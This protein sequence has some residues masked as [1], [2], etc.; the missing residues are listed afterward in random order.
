MRV[1]VVGLGKLGL[2]L[3]LLLGGEHDVTGIDLNE[4]TVSKLV[5]GIQPFIEP[6]LR[7]RMKISEVEY[8]S[9]FAGAGEADAT[10]IIVPTPSG[11]DGAFSPD[12]VVHAVELL[13]AELKG[14]SRPH[15]VVIVSTL[16]P[17]Q[18]ETVVQVALERASSRE[19]GTSLMLAY[20]PEFIALGDVFNGMEKPDLVLIGMADQRSGELTKTLLRSFIKNKPVFHSV[21]L[22]E[23][24]IAKIAIN[25]FITTKISYANYLKELCMEVGA[26]A[27]KVAA[28]VGT[29]SRI[30][31]KYFRP[32]TPYG[33]P[34]FPR[35]ARAF[36]TFSESL[37]IGA[38]MPLATATVNNR[39]VDR[40]KTLILKILPDGGQVGILGLSYK[41]GTWVSE[42]S[43][44][45]KLAEELIADGV[46]VVAYDPLARVDGIDC[47]DRMDQ[48]VGSSDVIVVATDWSEFF[49]LSVP[50]NAFVIRWS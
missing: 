39:Q 26:D 21:S 45:R 3:A 34:C 8:T 10:F 4:E 18:T 47:K 33:G 38:E 50:Q 27:G 16:M 25:T 11:P 15:L 35:D 42:E 43:A 40:I 28:A 29:D 6:Q 46:K 49:G 12:Y 36:A 13:G 30:G 22:I 1:N 41:P 2:P 48:V 9:S 31:Q 5:K 23:A 20:S 37:G 14:I 24:E 44:G 19:V 32:G 17:G 7:D